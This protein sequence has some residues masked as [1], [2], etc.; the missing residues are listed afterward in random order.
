M[1]PPLGTNKLPYPQYVTLHPIILC[2]FV[3]S[4]NAYKLS[5]L[6]L[7]V[8]RAWTS[9][10]GSREHQS[11]N[12]ARFHH[13]QKGKGETNRLWYQTSDHDYP[14]TT[15]QKSLVH[16]ICNLLHLSVLAPPSR[17]RFSRSIRQ[18]AL[19]LLGSWRSWRI[20]HLQSSSRSTCRATI[21]WDFSFRNSPVWEQNAYHA[22]S[23]DNFLTIAWGLHV[24]DQSQFQ[25]SIQSSSEPVGTR[26][27]QPSIHG[28]QCSVLIYKRLSGT[29][30][31]FGLI[32]SRPWVRPA[33]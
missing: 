20:F 2:S 14:L 6:S 7:A 15:Q 4:L 33:I 19:H 22:C 9:W 16:N 1:K 11:H 13:P 32:R 24:S 31:K 8:W 25:H 18:V 27:K 12:L 5:V 26:A 23:N 10:H 28:D 17:A 29:P 21:R 3:Q 30:K